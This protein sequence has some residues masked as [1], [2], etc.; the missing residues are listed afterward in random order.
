[1]WH[2]QRPYQRSSMVWA[3]VV[4]LTA[5]KSGY[6]AIYDSLPV[7]PGTASYGRRCKRHI[8]FDIVSPLKACLQKLSKACLQ[9]PQGRSHFYYIYIWYCTHRRQPAHQ[10]QHWFFKLQTNIIETW[11]KKKEKTWNRQKNVCIAYK[12]H[13]RKHDRAAHWQP[14]SAAVIL[15]VDWTASVHWVRAKRVTPSEADRPPGPMDYAKWLKLQFRVGDLA[16]CARKK[17]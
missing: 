17:K 13:F 9:V 14:Q 5:L 3:R 10:G 2:F 11:W 1:M 8:F 6:D 16:G 15:L 7:Q 4:Q 12:R